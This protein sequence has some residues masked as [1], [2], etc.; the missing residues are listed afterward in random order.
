[1]NWLF[2]AR[3]RADIF[4]A[5]TM[6][7][8]EIIIETR[9]LSRFGKLNDTDALELITLA[10]EN[11]LEV[12]LEWDILMSEEDFKQK[13]IEFKKWEKYLHGV[14]LQ[15]PGALHWC[16]ENSELPL[17][18]IAENG[19]HNEVGLKTW[20]D[21]YRGRLQRISLSLELPKDVIQNYIKALDM[22]L[23]FLGLGRI[24]LFYTPRNLLSPLVREK[25]IMNDIEAM[26]ESEESPHKGFPILENSHGTFMFHIKEFCILDNTDEMKSMGL[27]TLRIDLRWVQKEVKERVYS[28]LKSGGSIEELKTFYPEDLMKGYF[29]VNKTD[30]LFSKLKNARLQSREGSY[31]GEVI[32]SEKS[33]HLAL[34]IKTERGLNI[35]DSLRILHPKGEEF[36]TKVFWIKSITGKEKLSAQ[37]GEVVLIPYMTGVWVKSQIF[38]QNENDT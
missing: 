35:G 28:L 17:L 23:E 34:S 22:P 12:W 26:G 37:K 36:F 5:K 25:K 20:R 8:K 16:Y 33:S 1:M 6:E 9:T 2:Y 7:A 18:F 4:H 30:V 14:R 38:I 29:H 32:E 31:V 15:D 27:D 13:K 24:L 3:E 10:R 19:N 21:F 11:H